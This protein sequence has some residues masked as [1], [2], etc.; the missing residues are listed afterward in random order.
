MRGRASV[1]DTSAPIPR[2]YQDVQAKL[3][4]KLTV[5]TCRTPR[6]VVKASRARADKTP[7]VTAVTPGPSAASYSMRTPRSA[8]SPLPENNILSPNNISSGGNRAA[9]SRRLDLSVNDYASPTRDLPNYVV[10]GV[11]PHTRVRS[12]T[13]RKK[14]D[15]LTDLGRKMSPNTQNKVRRIK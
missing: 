1:V 11:S 12:G 9:A 4:K 2:V 15:W 6:S 14:L 5:S 10:D 13:K 7:D 8:L 3:R